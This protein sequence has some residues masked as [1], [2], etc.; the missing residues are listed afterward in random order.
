[1]TLDLGAE[2][3]LADDLPLQRTWSGDVIRVVVADSLEITLEGICSL[4][5][6]EEGFTVVGQARSAEVTASLLRDARPRV[7]MFDADLHDC[8]AELVSG[9][10]QQHP[11][12]RVILL[13]STPQRSLVRQALAAGVTG[14]LVKSS[15]ASAVHMAVRAVA[16]GQVFLD[17]RL[18]G[19]VPELTNDRRRG[20]VM[21]LSPAE[22]RVLERLPQGLTNRE[23]GL[24]LDISEH[25]VKSH[26]R[27]LIR[28][29][30]CRDRVQAATIAVR[31]GLF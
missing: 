21:G 11:A 25:T 8:A 23:I 5:R 22:T 18:A 3:V 15:P 9:W 13:L 16:N 30:E 26:L 12:L 19:L 10:Q 31:L 6:G 14:L 28:K 17:E 4:L 2:A 7:L 20:G 1:M 27:S 24:E 29:L